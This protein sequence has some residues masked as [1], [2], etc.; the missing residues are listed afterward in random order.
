MGGVVVVVV[1]VDSLQYIYL[2][3]HTLCAGLRF[4]RF[5]SSSTLLSHISHRFSTR[6]RN[7]IFPTP[8]LPAVR[9]PLPLPGYNTSEKSGKMK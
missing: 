4:W 6:A 7:L 2:P 5:F 1:F 9:I 8:P 3:K